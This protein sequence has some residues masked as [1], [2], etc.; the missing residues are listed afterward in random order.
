MGFLET[1]SRLLQGKPAFIDPAYQ[2]ED[3][4]ESEQFNPLVAHAQDKKVANNLVDASGR[5]IVPELQLT[6]MK[7]HVNGDQM[8]VT[9]WVTNPSP[10][11]VR[12]DDIVVLKQKTVSRRELGPGEAHEATFYH[13]PVAKNDY[14]HK[15]QVFYRLMENGD[16]FRADYMVEY[17]RQSD[18]TYLV[19]DLHPE[20]PIH[21]V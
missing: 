17:N 3:A 9:A 16:C 11:R 21:D 4:K 20:R 6:H 18:G 19:E 1:M 2:Q 8:T 5:K 13:G 7:S 14:E 12:I 15:A 10:H